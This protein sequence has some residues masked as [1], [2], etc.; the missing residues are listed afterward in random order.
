[1]SRWSTDDYESRREEKRKYE[2]DVFYDVWRSGGN[3]DRINYDRVSDGYYDGRDSE[4]MAR[5]ELRAMRPKPE[6]EYEEEQ[7]Y[8][9]EQQE[10][11]A[12]T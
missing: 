5:S 8:P 2:N 10:E 4:S 11:P 7:Q 12:N 3:P 9:D 1:M 6:P